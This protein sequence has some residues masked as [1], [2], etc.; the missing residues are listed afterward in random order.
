MAIALSGAAAHAADPEPKKRGAE[1]QIF[2]DNDKWA[3]TDHYYTNGMKI[4]FGVDASNMP[5]LDLSSVPMGMLGAALKCDSFAAASKNG[6][7][8]VG[9]NMYTPRDV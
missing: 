3:K 9:Q 8:F 2:V 7:F 1:I 5:G 6:G 4:G